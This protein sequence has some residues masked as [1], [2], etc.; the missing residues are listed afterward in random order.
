MKLKTFMHDEEFGWTI[1]DLPNASHKNA[2]VLAFGGSGLTQESQPI[3][4]LLA[5]CKEGT[6]IGCST[7]GEI[8][9]TLVYDNSLS[10]A[11]LEFE[12]TEIA[13]ASANVSNSEDSFEAGWN[14]AQS[15]MREDLAG[16]FVLSD[17]TNVNGSQLVRGLNEVVPPEVI[18]TGGLAGDGT[19]FE[20]TWVLS[21]EGIHHDIVYAV[22]FYGDAIVIGHGSKGGWD[23]FGPERLITKS[24]DNTLF[25]L[26]G[27]PA[28]ELYKTYLGDRA[29][30]LPGTALLFPL[31]L[32][33]TAGD[34][35][36]VVRT[37]LSV[38]EETQS[39]TFAGDVPEGQRVQLM[40]ANFERLIDGAADAALATTSDTDD[41]P[42][43]SIAI[44]CVG[45]RLVLGERTEEE[46]EATMDAL[47]EGSEQI[48]FYSYGEISPYASG[49]CDL[50][51]QTMTLTTIIEKV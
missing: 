38:D 23:I 21:N 1:D 7:S 46:L 41:S 34:Q 9:D 37:I 14:I 24:K 44:S 39:M 15:L 26:D 42:V 50:H 30:G 28:L 36:S 4:D 17:G 31:A 11:V 29:A 25:E 8:F 20:K 22:A 27:K 40:K 35:K 51:N 16:I 12:H 48:G 2:L 10:V 47:P 32:R 3:Q 33:E 18:I 6:I 49:S 5:N 43:L 19:A 45:R 13:T